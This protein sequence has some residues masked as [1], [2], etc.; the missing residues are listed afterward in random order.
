MER[1]GEGQISIFVLDMHGENRDTDWQTSRELLPG[2]S[3]QRQ[4]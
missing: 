1:D 2:Q 3:G 4:S